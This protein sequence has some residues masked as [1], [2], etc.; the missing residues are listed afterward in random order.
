MPLENPKRAD[1]PLIILHG[2]LAPDG[3]VAKVSGVKVRRRWTKVFDSEEAAIDAVL[4]DKSGRWRWFVV[5]YVGQKG[6]PQCPK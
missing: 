6:G 2:N 5:R 3:A 4:A 1:G